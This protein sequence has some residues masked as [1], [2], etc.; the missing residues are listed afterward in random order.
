MERLAFNGEMGLLLLGIWHLHRCRSSTR[1]QA[2]SCW[3]ICVRPMIP[4]IC[5]GFS[6]SG[7]SCVG[8][9]R[10]ITD[11]SDDKG[12]SYSK[13]SLSVFERKVNDHTMHFLSSN[14]ILLFCII[15][16]LSGPDYEAGAHIW[17]CFPAGEGGG[18]ARQKK[19]FAWLNH[20]A[21]G[22]FVRTD[23]LLQTVSVVVTV[24]TVNVLRSRVTLAQVANFGDSNFQ[25]EISSWPTNVTIGKSIS[26]TIKNN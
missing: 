4:H 25:N 19:H 21:Y 7:C 14:K 22:T 24:R 6:G 1:W 20:C 26:N 9:S 3:K 18:K 16:L 13:S 8:Y 2:R 10:L 17:P 23:K 5:G 11:V 15:Y 12:S